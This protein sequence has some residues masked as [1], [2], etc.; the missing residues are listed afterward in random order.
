MKLLVD[1]KE[2]DFRDDYGYKV[3]ILGI[4]VKGWVPVG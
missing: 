1:G 2:D 4:Y 3:T